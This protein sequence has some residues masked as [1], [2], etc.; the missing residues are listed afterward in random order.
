MAA[1][2]SGDSQDVERRFSELSRTYADAWNRADLTTFGAQWT[3]DAIFWPPTGEELRGRETIQA[4][5]AKLGKT[6][7][8]VIE[9]L[10]AEPLGGATFVVGNFTQDLTLQGAPVHYRGGFTAIVVE[11]E[12]GPKMHRLVSFQERNAQT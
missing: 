3:E 5:T 4:W 10:Y 6:D 9:P 12:Q 11:T 2:S 8:L 7:N 1:P